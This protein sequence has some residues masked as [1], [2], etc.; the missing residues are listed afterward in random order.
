MRRVALGL[1]LAAAGVGAWLFERAHAVVNGCTLAPASQGGFGADSG[2]ATQVWVGYAGFGLVVGGLM[3]VAIA[4]AVMRRARSSQ[5]VV[6]QRT[7]SLLGTPGGWTPR[8]EAIDPAIVRPLR[9]EPSDA[10]P[11]HTRPSSAA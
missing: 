7:R 9:S 4:L 8:A 5:G 11:G 2:C 6:L 3:V 1:G 10:E